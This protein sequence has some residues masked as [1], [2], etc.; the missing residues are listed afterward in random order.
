M[1][2]IKG[3]QRRVE[4]VEVEVTSFSLLNAC[5]EGLTDVDL[6]QLIRSRVI[7]KCIAA[8]PELQD[9]KV[10]F[11]KL[12]YGFYWLVEDGINHHD[13]TVAMKSVRKVTEEE[14]AMIKK[15]EEIGELLTTK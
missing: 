12:S 3:L 2:V 4:Q 11:S 5:K 9:K 7:N 8:S 14:L 15:A 1:T 10:I 13:H 6:S